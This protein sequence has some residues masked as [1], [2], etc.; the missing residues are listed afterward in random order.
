MNNSLN[1][2]A[3]LLCLSSF[4]AVPVS[5]AQPV[6]TV[7]SGF[8]ADKENMRIFFE[9]LS[10][11][12]NKPVIVSNL[13]AKKRISGNFDLS[14]PRNVL[15]KVT[16]KMSLIWYDDGQSVYVYDASELKNAII[17]LENISVASVKRFLESSSLS[18]SRYPIRGDDINQTFYVSGPPVYIS[19]IKDTASYLDKLNVSN[20]SDAGLSVIPLYNTFAE[21]RHYAYRGEALTIPGMASI[22]NGLLKDNNGK[23]NN[24]IPAPAV[25]DI[26]AEDGISPELSEEMR[27]V[28]APLLKNIRTHSRALGN[29]DADLTVVSNPGNNSLLVRGDRDQVSN[30]RKLVSLLDIKKRHIEMSVWIIDLQKD[31]LEQLGVN[32]KGQFSLGTKGLISLNGGLSSTV[33][34]ASFMAS[35]MALAEKDKANIVSRPM[36]LTQENVPALFDNNRTFYT[37]LVGERTTSLD[38]V[39]YGTSLNVLPRFTGNNEIEMMLSVE[40]GNEV[41]TDNDAEILPEVGRTNISTVAR[42]PH[43]KSLLIGGYTRNESKQQN[44][45]IPVLKDIPWLGRMFSYSQN[46]SSNMVRVFLIQPREIDSATTQDASATVAAIRKDVSADGLQDWMD[47]FLDG[48]R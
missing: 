27:T 15:T 26:T 6:D 30:I 10:V 44:T 32:W 25:S 7:K 21:D 42:V 16:Q 28:P 19:L 13:A 20:T 12:L 11:S 36:L 4:I 8:V 33:D 39:T 47:N 2:K 37:R 24:A 46:R 40:D 5:V 43:G 18:D 45:G 23:N 34:G 48:S 14:N 1:F 22:I 38:H 35:V 31:E 17:R 9:A 29:E 3:F 41:R